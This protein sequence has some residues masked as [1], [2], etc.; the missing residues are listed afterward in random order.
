MICPRCQTTL[1]IGE[2]KGVEIDYCP[3]CRGIW[4]DS[5]ELDKILERSGINERYRDNQNNG[6]DNRNDTDRES[7]W[8]R[9]LDIFD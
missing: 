1:C 4:L 8:E 6:N 5:G 7:W 2:R 3:N 9:I